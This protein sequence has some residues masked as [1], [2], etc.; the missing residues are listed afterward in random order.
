MNITNRHRKFHKLPAIDHSS[1]IHETAINCGL[2][3]S[4]LGVLIGVLIE[5]QM[6]RLFLPPHPC[7][8]LPVSLSFN[9]RHAKTTGALTNPLTPA[10]VIIFLSQG[11]KI[12]RSLVFTHAPTP[13]PFSRYLSRRPHFAILS[14]HHRRMNSHAFLPLPTRTNQ[15]AI[16]QLWN[17]G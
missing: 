2:I 10:G 14:V 5:T 7:H 4:E 13:S 12:Q 6:P 11:K 8:P 9:Y 15:P 3:G 1:L 16:Q 17:S